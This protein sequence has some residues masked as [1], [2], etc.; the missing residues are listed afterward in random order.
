[1]P[2]IGTLTKGDGDSETGIEIESAR[3]R[4]A[5]ARSAIN[6]R[7]AKS[8][9]MMG[10]FSRTLLKSLLITPGLEIYRISEQYLPVAVGD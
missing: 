3:H 9:V 10:V 6:L 4:L 5:L 1:M 2:A 8:M 7:T